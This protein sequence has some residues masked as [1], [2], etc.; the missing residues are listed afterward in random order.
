MMK[1]AKV[2]CSSCHMELIQASG[3]TT[4]EAYIEKGA[5]K[6]AL[7]LGA[8]RTKKESCLACHDQAKDLKEVTNKK[9]T[10]APEA[11]DRQECPVLGMPRA[12]QALFR[13]FEAV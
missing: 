2:G 7:V 13:R 6:T 8:G 3:G 12:D 1:D 9:L 10:D 5:L 11:C 4:Y